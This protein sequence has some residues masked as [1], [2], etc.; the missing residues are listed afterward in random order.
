MTWV[1]G[2]AG[3]FGH[4]IGLSDIRITLSDGSEHDCLQKVY[5][6]GACIAL[7]FAGSVKIGLEIANR[8]SNGLYVPDVEG[9]WDPLFVARSMPEDTKRL[10]DRFPN[11]EK[12]LG[13]H[14]ML[15]SV[16]PRR[17]DGVAPWARCYVHILKSPNFEPIEAPQDEIVSIGS[18]SGI[19]VY[20][21]ALSSLSQ[22]MEVF[23][24]EMGMPG[25]SGLGIMATITDLLNNYPAPGISRF[26]HL[27]LVGRDSIRISENSPF[28]HSNASSGSKMPKIATNMEELEKILGQ[29]GVSSI[30]G[31]NC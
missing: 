20:K 14:L 6:I 15:L 9:K 28:I 11:S 13:C 5:R 12:D 23:K 24:L 16:D 4:A 7:G 3:P 19:S 1:I 29:L 31:I 10:F 8:L 21:E 2:R 30:E 27:V 17:N 18:G 25:G 22:D 26:L